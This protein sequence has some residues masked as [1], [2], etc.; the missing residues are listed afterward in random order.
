M[1]SPC[2]CCARS[3]HSC[4]Q[5]YQIPLTAGDIQRV[6]EFL[7]NTDFY[8]IEVP[9]FDDISPDYDPSWLP[10]I[11][12][13]DHRVRVLKRTPEKRCSL[14]TESGCQL[15]WE[16]RPLICRLYPYTYTETGILGIDASCPISCG[17]GWQAAL[18]DMEMPQVRAMQ[19]VSQLYN[20]FRAG[21]V[22]S[23]TAR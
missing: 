6:A 9:V 10:L 19:W 1:L 7:G 4:C 17:G 23:G 3:G 18:A 15:P 5:G 14:L 12:E 8:R 16:R 11:E 20:E 2:V 21:A 13:P 22:A